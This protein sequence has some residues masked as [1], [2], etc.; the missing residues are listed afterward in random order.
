MRS[1][2][3]RSY[4]DFKTRQKEQE[5]KKTITALKNE[6]AELK[7]TNAT[8]KTMHQRDMKKINDLS[9]EEVAEEE[10]CIICMEPK[11]GLASLPCEHEFCVSCFAQHARETNTCPL[12]RDEFTC[13]PKKTEHLSDTLINGMV[14]EWADNI[15]PSYFM[16]MVGSY[17]KKTFNKKIE[18]LHWIVTAN[19]KR[20]IKSKVRRYYEE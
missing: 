10:Q 14:D 19:A 15:D 8:F 16:R 3:S 7:K 9:G 6:A 1:R 12:C 13:K 5:Y 11:I 4:I 20:I 18:F 17:D 2:S